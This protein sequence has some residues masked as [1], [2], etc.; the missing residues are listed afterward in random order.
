[1][2]SQQA[3]VPERTPDSIVIPKR[4][5]KMENALTVEDAQEALQNEGFKA[6]LERLEDGRCV[7]HSGA[8]GF[9]IR[10][11]VHYAKDSKDRIASLL[12]TSGFSTTDV[13]RPRLLEYAN[14][15]NSEFRYAKT[16]VDDENGFWLEQD[17][18]VYK[19]FDAGAVVEHFNCYCA[20]QHRFTDG[21]RAEKIW[22]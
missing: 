4:S 6:K 20:M 17:A 2:T 21:L 16:Y 8:N 3:V 22:T 15:F 19:G 13:E 11:R 1:M 5:P 7:I 10:I 9:R 14:K 18:I 12:Y